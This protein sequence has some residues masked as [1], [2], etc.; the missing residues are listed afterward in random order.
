MGYVSPFILIIAWPTHVNALKS[1]NGAER[2]VD[3]RYKYIFHDVKG[4]SLSQERRVIDHNCPVD[5]EMSWSYWL[6]YP[7][8]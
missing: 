5:G 1:K 3:D 7:V 2:P 8:M 6:F 4:F